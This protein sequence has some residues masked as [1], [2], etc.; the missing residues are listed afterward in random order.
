MVFD[1]NAISTG[2]RIQ[3]FGL[4]DLAGVYQNTAKMRAKGFLVVAFLKPLDGYSIDVAKELQE[5]ST[6]SDKL[7]VAAVTLGER[8]DAEELSEVAGVTYPILW[9]YDTYLAPL[10]SVTAAPTIFIT[11]AQGM[12]IAR[13]VGANKAELAEARAVLSE[14]VRKV[15]EAARAAAE[16]AAAA[17]QAA[18]VKA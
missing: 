16:A 4:C 10:W 11:D 15:E 6:M 18:P 13:V 2:R 5:W 1:R 14:A 8:V 17:A 7:A 3:D 12:V 9:D